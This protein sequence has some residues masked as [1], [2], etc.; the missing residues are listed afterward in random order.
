MNFL[1]GRVVGER[2]VVGEGVELLLPAGM[3]SDAATVCGGGPEHLKLDDADLPAEVVVIEPM[4][5][6]TQ[7]IAK[8]GETP[9]TIVLSE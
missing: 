7:I 3:G 4:G 8:V 2:F 1:N 6:S 9:I 5:S